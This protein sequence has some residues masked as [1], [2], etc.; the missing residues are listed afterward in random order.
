M[1]LPT[2]TF[3]TQPNLALATNYQ[4][5][6][7]KSPAAS[8]SGW[9]INLNHQGDTIFATWFTYDVDGTPM[10]LVVTAPKTAP[11]VYSGDLYRTSGAR[12]DAFVGA[13]VVPV[14]VGT[15][16]F[17]FTDGNTATFAYDITGVGPTRVTQSRAITREIFTAPGTACQ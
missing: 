8:E 6:W 1:P 2:C 9:G 13:N 5:I 12:F 7:W 16:A 15:A 14:K 11:G 17:T 3:G 4:D 10:W